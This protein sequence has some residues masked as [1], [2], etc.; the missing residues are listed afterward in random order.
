MSRIL[1]LDSVAGVAGDMFAAAFVDAGLV[2]AAELA[3]LPAQ[4]GFASVEISARA[5]TKAT[6]RATHLS[7]T[8]RSDRAPHSLSH[9]HEG[10]THAHQEHEPRAD[11]H[12]AH[13]GPTPAHHAHEPHAHETS[14]ASD[15]ESHLVVEAGADHAHTHY[16]D[17]DRLIGSCPLAAPVR[18]RAQMIF[19]LLAEAEAAA[20]GMAVE[21][22]AFHEV[23]SI[24]S[25]MDV[26]MAA[27]CIEKLGPARYCATPIRPGRGFITMAHG[28]HP[29]PPPASARLL[30]DMPIAAT[31]AAITRTNVELSTPTGI[32]ILKSLAPE[33]LAEVPAGTIRQQGL[34]AGTM[35]L[36]SFPNVF[37][38][39]VLD[40][41]PSPGATHA[42]EADQVV[43][44]VS[45]ID[46]DSAEHI[47]WLAEQLLARGAL[48]VWLTPAMGKKGRPLTCLSVLAQA[49]DWSAYADWLLRNSTTFGLRYR[50][51]DRL[52]LARRFERRAVAGGELTYKVGLTTTG[53]VLKDKPEFDEQ[54]VHWERRSGDRK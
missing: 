41:N 17:I 23:G 29:V 8:S 51:W 43:E 22:V 49:A 20:H 18:A 16:A 47:A 19:R 39:I 32:A 30:A 14:P 10:P 21:D 40:A 13:E 44:I 50:T 34:G 12:H 2:T 52:K 38:L 3:A 5:V 1:F 45:N 9:A 4:L 48:D 26:V 46:D 27:Y 25:I 37:R 24:D 42:Y 54:R 35:D 53:E 15:S 6:M 28:T 36:G 11:D 31:P 33:F 7:V